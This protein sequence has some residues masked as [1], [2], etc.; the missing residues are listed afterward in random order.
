MLDVF[1]DRKEPRMEA[2]RAVQVAKATRTYENAEV[3]KHRKAM[4]STF[5]GRSNPVVG[6]SDAVALATSQN[7]RSARRAEKAWLRTLSRAEKRT[8]H[9]YRI[10]PG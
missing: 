8:L 5:N 4:R 3:R 9:G 1:T 10:I 7:A 2:V 6:V